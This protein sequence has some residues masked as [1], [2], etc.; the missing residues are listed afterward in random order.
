MIKYTHN[1]MKQLRI[2][3]DHISLFRDE[4][5]DMVTHFVRTGF[6]DNTGNSE[7]FVFME[8][9]YELEPYHS[10]VKMLSVGTI[11]KEYGVNIP[12]ELAE[13][14]EKIT[15]LMGGVDKTD[16]IDLNTKE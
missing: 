11:E 12:K 10:G 8:D 5:P 15:R 9:A 16:E 2:N 4:E 7:W 14:Q 1:N 3:P 6:R 13:R